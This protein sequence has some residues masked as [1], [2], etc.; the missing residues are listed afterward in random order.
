LAAVVVGRRWCERQFGLAAKD[1]ERRPQFV[2]ERSAEL[3]HL[4][5]RMLDPCER[6]VEGSGHLIEL[7]AGAA[8]GESS[9][10]VRD[11]DGLRRTSQLRQGGQSAPG[12][13]AARER[14]HGKAAQDVPQQES[15]EPRERLVDAVEKVA[16][17]HDVGFTGARRD[18][19]ADQTEPSAIRVHVVRTWIFEE[20]GHFT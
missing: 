3:P 16:H 6:V 8:H 20:L 17:L 12:Q 4:A 1:G 14:G 18:H 5:H 13:P 9:I 7:V 11:A 15:I 19:G 2:R 10:E